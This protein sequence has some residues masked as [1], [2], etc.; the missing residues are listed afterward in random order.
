M[1][2]IVKE[3]VVKLNVGNSFVSQEPVFFKMQNVLIAGL[4]GSGLMKAVDNIVLNLTLNYSPVELGIQYYSY[5]GFDTPWSNRAR[6]LPHMINQSY[7]Q[8]GPD[9]IHKVFYKNVCNC[10][11]AAVAQD[12][13]SKSSDNSFDIEYPCNNRKNVIIL[14][15]ES[16]PA[17]KIKDAVSALMK[18]TNEHDCNVNVIVVAHYASEFVNSLASYAGLR[19]GT[20]VSPRLSSSMFGHIIETEDNKGGFVWVMERDNPYLLQCLSIPF[21]PDSLYGKVCKFLSNAKE[22]GQD[23]YGYILTKLREDYKATMYVVL[24]GYPTFCDKMFNEDGFRESFN[25][26]DDFEVMN[27]FIEFT[28]KESSLSSENK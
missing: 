19:I 9:T 15:I 5:G 6:R 17:D 10:L 2:E 21:R 8:M 27:L 26:A 18:F 11:A 23:V 1:Y 20:K 3:K 12:S 4:T 24:T 28:V 14:S 7:D 25:Q 22:Y 13:E 16:E